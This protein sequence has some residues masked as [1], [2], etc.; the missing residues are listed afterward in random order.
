MKSA[1]ESM[2]LKFTADEV[3]ERIVRAIFLCSP[4]GSMTS[5]QY[6]LKNCAFIEMLKIFKNQQFSSSDLKATNP[7]RN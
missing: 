7:Y 3:G 5:L 6:T 4:N 1:L 2:S